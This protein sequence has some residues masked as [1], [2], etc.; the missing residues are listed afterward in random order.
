[1][2]LTKIENIRF[3]SILVVVILVFF[4]FV[5]GISGMLT[6]LGIILFLIVPTYLILNNFELEQDEK[7]IFSFFIGVGIFPSAT[8]WLGMVISFRIAIIVVFITF[9]IVAYLIRYVNLVEDDK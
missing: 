6:A 5:L 7:M 4:Y 9:L 1:M 3:I 2:N 8:Y